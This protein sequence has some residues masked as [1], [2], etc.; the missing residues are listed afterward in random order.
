[1]SAMWIALLMREAGIPSG[2][3][4][5]IHGNK[6]TVRQLIAHRLVRAVSFVGT[7][8]AG[9]QVYDLCC[10]YRKRIQA[11]MGGKNHTVILPDSPKEFTVT[12]LIQ[13]CFGST[14]QR[15]TSPKVAVLVGDA[16]TWVAD[17][18]SAAKALRIGPPED[19]G[20]DIGPMITPEAKIKLLTQIRVA[21]DEGA[22]VVLDGTQFHHQDYPQ[23]NW[24]GPTILANVTTD[25]ACY[26]EETFGPLLVCINV[27][28][29]EE[30]IDMINA[31][32]FGNGCSIFTSNG[33]LSRQ[34]QRD[35]NIGIVNINNPHTAPQSSFSFTSNKDSFLGESSFYGP[36]CVN[37]FTFCKTVTSLWHHPDQIARAHTLSASP[38]TNPP[39]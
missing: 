29:L 34:F 37:F 32:R 8:A 26:N 22:E 14:G 15:C 39:T 5:V 11:N 17:F 27:N 38:T 24:L 30:A 12:A 9:N 6:S 10:R 4:S 3:L 21:R 1:M 36:D 20:V 16:R 19:D 13:S 2:V 7:E 28:S 31:N 23:G 35:V 18:I 25:M 33:A